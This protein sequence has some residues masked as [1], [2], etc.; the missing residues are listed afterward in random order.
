MAFSVPWATMNVLIEEGDRANGLASERRE[1]GCLKG[2]NPAY[3][4]RSEKN[5]PKFKKALLFP[6]LESQT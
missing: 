1:G 5:Q 3:K 6:S 4:Y 2:S